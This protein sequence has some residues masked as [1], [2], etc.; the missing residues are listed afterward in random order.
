MYIPYLIPLR[1]SEY[2]SDSLISLIRVSRYSAIDGLVVL[3]LITSST[4][5]SL[6]LSSLLTV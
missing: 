4:I 5:R 3:I 2:A 6:P 1:L